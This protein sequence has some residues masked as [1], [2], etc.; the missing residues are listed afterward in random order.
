[1]QDG[2]SSDLPAFLREWGVDATFGN[3]GGLLAKPEGPKPTR[4][5]FLCQ[6]KSDRMGGTLG[7]TT[8][9]IHRM[10]LKMNQVKMIGGVTYER[11][12]DRGLWIRE[13]R[14]GDLR[15]LEVDTIVNC[16][17]QLSQRALQEPLQAQGIPAFLIGGAHLAQELDAQRAI[18][19]GA[20][21][22][23]RL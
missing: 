10:S 18:R 4:R 21:L 9:W 7:K 1:V 19:E 14:E 22:A 12:D 2:V 3:R 5:V 17:G 11:I 6:R 23:A 16:S 8:G 20:E 13:G 15:C